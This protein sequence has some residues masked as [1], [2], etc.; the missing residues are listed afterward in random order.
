MLLGGSFPARAHMA[1]CG[2][3]LGDAWRLTMGEVVDRLMTAGEAGL[4]LGLKTSTIRRLTWSGQL[5][6]V[7]PTGRRAVRY[8]LRDLEALVRLRSEPMRER[9]RS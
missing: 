1:A 9:R 3:R 2:M 6:V 4:F 5:P 8:R 7:R